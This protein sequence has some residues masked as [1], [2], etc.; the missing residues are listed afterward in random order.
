[1]LKKKFQTSSNCN[2]RVK[3]FIEVSDLLDQTLPQT[4]QQRIKKI[5]HL[6]D[7]EE[8][9]SNDRVPTQTTKS[10][11]TFIRASDQRLRNITEIEEPQNIQNIQ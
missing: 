1:M 3:N 7:S 8:F 5:I 4:S 10:E 6:E 2:R 9:L 11:A